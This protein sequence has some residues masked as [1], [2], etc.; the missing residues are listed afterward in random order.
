[1]KITRV[2]TSK[3]VDISLLFIG[4]SLFVVSEAEF[5]SLMEQSFSNRLLSDDEF[6]C[7]KV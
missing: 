4:V 1:M 7:A 2:N 5:I 6:A 3:L